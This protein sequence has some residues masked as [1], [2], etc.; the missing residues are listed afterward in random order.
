M[1][2]PAVRRK[3]LG[4]LLALIAGVTVALAGQNNSASILFGMGRH[5]RYARALIV[6][7]VLTI[8]GIALV[9]RPFGIIGVAC[10][11]STM[12][13]LNRGLFT[14][15]LLSHEVGINY[16]RFL[17]R[18]YQPL[19]L[20]AP[21]MAL[22]YLLRFTILPGRNWPQLILAGVI[23]VSCYFPLALLALREDHR[24]LLFRKLRERV[25]LRAATVE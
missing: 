13:L 22:L 21:V 18:V 3:L 5:Q 20:A 4:V 9:V 10:V 14:A 24:E 2:Q 23:C 15:W 11:V 7:A 25:R 19:L 1:D 17:A 6:E 8:S 12:M 16:F